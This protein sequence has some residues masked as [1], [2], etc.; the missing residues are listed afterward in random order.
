MRVAIVNGCLA[1]GLL[2]LACASLERAAPPA[3]A[4]AVQARN[5]WAEP[6]RDLLVPHCGRCH[7][8]SLPTSKPKA[9]A[10]FDFTENPWYSRLH[11]EQYDALL[12]R[13]RGTEAI[14]KDADI[15]EKFVRCARDKTCEQARE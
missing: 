8:G 7:L 12:Q 5:A 15:V 14:A 1:P 2:L 9:L 6:T 13:V 10:I 4:P 3:D 11:G